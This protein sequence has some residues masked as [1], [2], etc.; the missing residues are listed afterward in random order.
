M[1]SA[2]QMVVVLALASLAPA[3]VLTATTFTRFAVVFSFLRMGLGTQGAPPGQVLIGLALFMTSFVM[4]PTAAAVH[5]R[6]LGPYLDGKMNER[7]ALEAATPVVREFLLKRT[8]T[9]DL[10][11]FYS[12]SALPRPSGPEDVPLRVALPAFALSELRT[13]FKMGIIVLL[14][15]LVV[16]LAVASI[17]SSLGMVMLP[18]HVIAMPIKLLLFLAADGWRLIVLSL[19]KG[20]T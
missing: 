3:I 10:E 4:A 11:V 17:L 9:E 15:F 19:L 1:S 13:A 6:A 20:V 2:V 7:A 12:V 16:D 5:E 14:P 8:R 18:P